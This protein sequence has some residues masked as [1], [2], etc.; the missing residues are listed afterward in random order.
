LKS[1]PFGRWRRR[2]DGNDIKMDLKA[3]MIG[4]EW[5]WLQPP[6]HSENHINMSIYLINTLKSNFLSL[7][8]VILNDI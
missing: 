1:A 8:K 5:N 6:P 3:K 2:W 4:G 7:L